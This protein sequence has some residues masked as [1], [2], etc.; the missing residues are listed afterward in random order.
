VGED[1]ITVHLTLCRK[2]NDGQEKSFLCIIR[3]EVTQDSFKLNKSEK[4]E[5]PRKHS[6]YRK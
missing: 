5:V 6:L 3:K 4:G 1:E 2:T